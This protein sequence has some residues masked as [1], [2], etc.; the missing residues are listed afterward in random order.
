MN[1]WERIDGVFFLFFFES[2]FCFVF[3]FWF[4]FLFVG[5]L[6]SVLGIYRCFGVRYR[7]NFV[8]YGLVYNSRVSRVLLLGRYRGVRRGEV[9]F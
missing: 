6:G 5:C 2:S 4:S 1:M 9:I 7:V 8:V 3:G